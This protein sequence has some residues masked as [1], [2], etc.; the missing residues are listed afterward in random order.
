MAWVSNAASSKCTSPT[1]AHR[2]SR[3]THAM[4][5]S[6]RCRREGASQPL[7]LARL[8]KRGVRYRTLRDLRP[9]RL[10]ARWVSLFRMCAPR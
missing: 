7:G 4:V 6:T 8:E 1:G 2:A 3:T 5:V 9:R 10:A